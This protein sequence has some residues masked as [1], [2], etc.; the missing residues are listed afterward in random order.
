MSTMAETD[1]HV[2]KRTGFVSKMD[3]SSAGA[4]SFLSVRKSGLSSMA[5]L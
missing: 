2:P 1:M 5:C 4:A 3:G